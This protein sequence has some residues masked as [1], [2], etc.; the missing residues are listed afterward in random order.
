MPGICILTDSTAQFPVPTFA[1]HEVVSMI[2]LHIQMDGQ[3]YTDGKDLKTSQLPT[4]VNQ[5]LRLQALPP[6]VDEFRQVFTTLSRK[7][8][9]I[10]AILISSHLSQTVNHAREAADTVHGPAVI[11]V[12]DSQVTAAGLGLLV[13]MASRAATRGATA[14]R[15]SRLMRGAVPRIYTVFC[16]QSL[17]YLYHSGY[18]DPAQAILGEMLGVMP[19]FILEN[20]KLVPIQKVRN[21][22]HLVDII[23]EFIAEFG[24]LKHI[25]LIQ[26][27]PPFEQEARSLRERINGDFPSATFSEH[28]LGTALGTILGPHSFGVVAME[29]CQD[30]D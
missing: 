25:A 13:Q 7:Y 6:T 4:S 29:N 12:I 17:T 20:G 22:R 28:N 9:D 18:L 30:F 1:G 21:S 16:L 24:N 8:S 27:V 11:Q 3:L 2:P 5:H 19:F 23:H 14:N 15:I 10:V 26:G